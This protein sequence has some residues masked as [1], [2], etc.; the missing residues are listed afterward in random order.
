MLIAISLFSATR[1]YSQKPVTKPG[2]ADPLTLKN[3]ADSFQYALGAY[4]GHY[5]ITGGFESVNLNYFLPALNDAYSNNPKL[6][7]DSISFAIIANYVAETEKVK[8]KIL[9]KQLFDVLKDKPGIG[10]LPSGVQYSIIKPGGKGP[11]P[12]ETD[13]VQIYFK[14]TLPDGRVFE[15]SFLKNTPVTVVPAGVIPGLKEILLLMTVGDTWE[16][17]I[18][19]ALAYGD[20]GNAN[21]PSNSALIITLEVLNIKKGK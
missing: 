15:N 1:S 17:F 6:I 12:L 11:K 14:E 16:I 4:I 7:P 21:I 20:K 9:E 13:T 3:K 18:P 10:K 8:G 5:M 2:T 19:S